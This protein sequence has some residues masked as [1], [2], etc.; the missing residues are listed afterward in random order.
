MGLVGYAV[1]RAEGI[2]S[3]PEESPLT[4]CDNVE[5]SAPTEA[6]TRDDAISYRGLHRPSSRGRW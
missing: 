5:D 2:G 4:V 1:E 3:R 6:N